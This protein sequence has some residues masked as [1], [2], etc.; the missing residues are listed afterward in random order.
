MMTRP[1]SSE[2]R[3]L[4]PASRERKA[5][6]RQSK[7]EWLIATRPARTRINIHNQGEVEYMKDNIFSWNML[8]KAYFDRH[9]KDG[10]RMNIQRRLAANDDNPECLDS[11]LALI[12]SYGDAVLKELSSPQTLTLSEHEMRENFARVKTWLDWFWNPRP[13]YREAQRAQLPTI[14][15][16]WEARNEIERYF[17]EF[18]ID[19]EQFKQKQGLMV[20]CESR[21]P[22]VE[23]YL[24]RSMRYNDIYMLIRQSLKQEARDWHIDF[25]RLR[26]VVVPRVEHFPWAQPWC[27]P[28]LISSRDRRPRG[29]RGALLQ[30]TSSVSTI[31]RTRPHS[32]ASRSRGP[33]RGGLSRL[34][35]FQSALGGGRG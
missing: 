6:L 11:P 12:I 32:S 31:P 22:V 9:L 17:E 10:N 7:D 3:I 8:L 13:G 1:S 29:E 16:F 35:S 5:K 25:A 34:V 33:R 26:N 27:G 18:E 24:R 14:E 15:G 21:Q 23:Q 19:P 30:R 20:L 2:R 28:G 4:S